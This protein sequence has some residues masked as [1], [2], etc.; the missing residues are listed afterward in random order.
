MPSVSPILINF[1]A[2]KVRILQSRKRRLICTS[3]IASAGI[4]GVILVALF[5]MDYTWTVFINLKQVFLR[6]NGALI[7]LARD[8]DV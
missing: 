4:Q 3:I 7:G 8:W 5:S 1:T 6:N 2:D